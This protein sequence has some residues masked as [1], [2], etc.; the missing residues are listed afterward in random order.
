[1]SY[2]STEVSALV[3]RLRITT[4]ARFIRICLPRPGK[5]S[6]SVIDK[7]VLSVE[8]KLDVYDLERSLGEFGIIKNVEYLLIS[9]IFGIYLACNC[10]NSFLLF[11]DIGRGSSD[12][13]E[14]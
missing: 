12:L 9:N 2:S 14:K 4:S 13:M 7:I 5:S 6:E 3:A 1:M 8:Q 10:S 11:F